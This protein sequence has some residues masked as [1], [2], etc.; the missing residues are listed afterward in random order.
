[1]P[2]KDNGK[3]DDDFNIKDAIEFEKNCHKRALYY[4]NM[5]VEAGS[6]KRKIQKFIR[7]LEQ[8]EKDKKEKTKETFV[9]KVISINIGAPDGKNYPTP[10]SEDETVKG[11]NDEF[12]RLHKS[13]FSK[14]QLK[15]FRWMKGDD[16]LNEK[17]RREVG[18]GR[19]GESGW[20]L[21]DGDSI[22]LMPRGVGGAKRARGSADGRP[23]KEEKTRNKFLEFQMSVAQISNLGLPDLNANKSFLTQS[24]SNIN[25]E[26]FENAIR[27]VS[28]DKAKAIVNFL[29][30][31]NNENSR[32]DFIA[33][34]FLCEE[35]FNRLDEM[36]AF[37]S[38]LADTGRTMMACIIYKAFVGE[39]SRMSWD[40]LR[41]TMVRIIE[42]KCIAHGRAVAGDFF[43]YKV[44]F[45]LGI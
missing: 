15:A 1:M 19:K 24:V 13:A 33:K 25:K 11:L 5:K 17:P 6:C 21:K 20:K 31:T 8:K 41:T 35:Y 4:W 7:D 16:D 38:L 14:K 10:I 32:M 12:F 27:E 28:V 3:L 18:G 22:N 42:E 39:N 26:T 30:T 37:T 2:K 29:F 36:E 23:S 40:N 44:R 9:P 34:T 45:Q 43:R